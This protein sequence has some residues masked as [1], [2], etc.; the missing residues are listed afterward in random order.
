MRAHTCDMRDIARARNFIKARD[1]LRMREVT[2]IMC[3]AS[4]GVSGAVLEDGVGVQATDNCHAHSM[5]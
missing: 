1:I 3:R 2:W 4:G 5:H